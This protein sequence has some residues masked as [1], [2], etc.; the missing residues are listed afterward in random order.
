M[1][2]SS[3]NARPEQEA[4]PSIAELFVRGSLDKIGLTAEQADDVVALI[5]EVGIGDEVRNRI[6][7]WVQVNAG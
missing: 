7:I 6:E 5:R 4:R 3:A 1:F 2:E